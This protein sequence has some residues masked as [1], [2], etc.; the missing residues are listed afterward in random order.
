LT[1]NTT[2]PVSRNTSTEVITAMIARTTGSLLL[3][4]Y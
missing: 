4:A 3:T 1:G 2:P